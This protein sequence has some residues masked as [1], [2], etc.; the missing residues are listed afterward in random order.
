MFFE[1]FIGDKAFYKRL[2]SVA[3]PIMIQNA[4][5][6]CVSL[7][8][9]VM[10]G[11]TGTEAMSGVSIVNQFIF[12][13]NLLSFG[14]IS[15]GSIF[16]AQFFGKGDD[17]GV[18]R[19]F[20]FKLIMGVAAAALSVGFL[21]LFGDGLIGTFLN[22]GSDGDLALAL[23]EGGRYLRVMLFGLLP[24]ILT[25]VYAST[26]REGGVVKVPMTAGVV[27][28]LTNL[29]F[30]Y[31]FIFGKLGAPEMGAVGA[32]VATVISRFAELAVVV[33]WSHLHLKRLP[34]LAGAYRSLRVGKELFIRILGKGLPLLANEFLWALG[35]T[36]RNQCYSERGLEAVAALNIASTVINVFAVMYMSVGH[37][38]TITVGSLL[39]AGRL[40]EARISARRTIA[41]SVFCGTVMGLLVAALSGLFPGFYNTAD[42]VKELA[43]F[44]MI[45]TGV[46]LPF[47]AFCHSSYF[48]LRSGGKVWVTLIFDSGFVWLVVFPIAFVLS[49]FTALDI[50]VIYAVCQLTD[51]LKVAFGLFLLEK[52]DWVRRLV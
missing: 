8:D 1:K 50:R 6:N 35:I 28:V 15:A 21:I 11:A 12:V 44:M 25:Q 18:R 23:D 19:T 3:V 14:V 36:F 13:F 26:L 22:E 31:I 10:V 33:L 47:A 16:S 32:G 41:F 51:V 7:L 29:V 2:L 39:G 43:S 46:S 52:V 4:V 24:Y 30:N 5:T 9:N 45:V 42:S 37:A 17:D 48:A 34:W 20:R 27:A 49:R 38:L 40:E